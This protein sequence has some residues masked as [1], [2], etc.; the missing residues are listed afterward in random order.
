[1]AGVAPNRPAGMQTSPSILNITPNEALHSRAAVPISVSSTAARSVRDL[2]IAE[3]DGEF[4]H[5]APHTLPISRPDEVK[6]AKEPI[7]R[8]RPT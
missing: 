6:A 5:A 1:M 7:L 4:L 3:E 8:W 2:R